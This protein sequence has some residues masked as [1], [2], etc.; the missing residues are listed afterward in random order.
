MKVKRCK[1]CGRP[2]AECN[3]E[4]TCFRHTKVRLRDINKAKF[5]DPI[6]TGEIGS[7]CTSRETTGFDIAQYQYHGVR[8]PWH[9][10]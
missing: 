4:D 9:A 5:I 10:Y 3:P 1:K 2:L 7:L 6:D 8:H